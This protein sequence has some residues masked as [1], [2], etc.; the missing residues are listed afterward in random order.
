VNAGGEAAEPVIR[1]GPLPGVRV[2]PARPFSDR[3]GWLLEV[4][5]LDEVA[6]DLAPRMGYVSM[7]FPGVVRGPHEHREQTDWFCFAGPSLFRLTLWDTREDS[8]A[9]GEK[10]VV[11]CGE[12]RPAIVVIPPGVVHAY[13]NIGSGEGLVFNCPNRLYAGESRRE[14]V[15]E[16]RHEDAPGSPFR[17]E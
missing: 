16:I 2:L 6:E 10:M 7:T 8:P 15:D 9:R 13:R 11:E 4:F 5:R 3:R 1:G 17:P 14:P 12:G